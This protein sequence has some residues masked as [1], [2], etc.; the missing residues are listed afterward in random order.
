MPRSEGTSSPAW[1]LAIV[2]L[3]FFVFL[4]FIVVRLFE[5][6]VVNY[7]FYSAMASGQH[8]ILAKL[9]PT[10]GEIFVND[11]LAPETH[12]PIVLNKYLTLVYAVPKAVLDAADAATKLAPIL[13]I[14]VGDLQNVL[15]KTADPYEP[16]KHL[17]DDAT[18]QAVGD[19]K[20]AGIHTSPEVVRY[21]SDGSLYGQLT[22]FMGYVGNRKQGQYG[23][24]GY[25]EDK[26]AGKFGELRSEKDAVGSL[27]ILGEHEL[28]PAEDGVDITLTIDKNIQFQA[29]GSLREAVK[30]HG[31]SSGSLVIMDPK[32]G[33][34]KALCGEP[35]FDPNVYNE[36]T[37]QSVFVS[38]AVSIPYEPGSVFKPFTM[39]AA[40]EQGKVTPNST[41]TDTGEVR[42]G[43]DVIRNSDLKAHG[44]Q[45]MAQVL[46]ESLNTG[47]IYAMRQIGTRVFADFVRKFG[48]GEATKVELPHEQGG[49]L[50][51][52]EQKSE[53]YY[54]T[55][56]FGQ[57]I[58]TTPLQL[59]AAFGALANGGKLMRPYVVD[60]L[61][62]ADGRVQTTEPTFVR[63][64]VS[65]AVATMVG[66]MLVA[67]VERGHGKRAAVPGYY[68]AGKTGTAEIS[69]PTGG[70]QKGKNIGTFVGY[71][72]VDDPKFVM[73]V[74]ISEPKDV[75]FAESSAAPV[76]GEVAKY[77]LEYYRVPPSREVK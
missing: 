47:A 41:Y 50:K 38:S 72:P 49:N 71:A 22:G 39:A 70:Y 2:R 18:A 43:P 66:G 28:T 3:V 6:Q 75:V 76:F 24:E 42:I 51:S 52:L 59:A 46:E 77:L 44:V 67:V 15:A 31:A 69:N 7:N 37:N 13:N 23:I 62:Y 20:L 68:V 55:A 4:M 10:R 8:D 36:V 11:P 35:N 9:V 14:P 53:I 56:S 27:I 34:I 61:H 32:T 1:R 16:L 5:L 26:L 25:W 33:A 65:P 21:Y 40:L 57:G 74:K 48:F 30:K 12:T 64:V 54:A 60:T 58:T 73:I 17:V 19:L 45:T 63:Q 29:C